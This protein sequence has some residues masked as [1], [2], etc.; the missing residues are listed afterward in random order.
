VSEDKPFDRR[1][2]DEILSHYEGQPGALIPVLQQTQEAYGYL[3]RPAIAVIAK[4][5]KMPAARVYGVATFYAQFHLKPRGK[6]IIRVCLGTACHVRGGEKIAAQLG[7]T[8]GIV[9][10]ETTADGL[11]TLE[12]VA[13]LGACGLAP[14]MVVNAATYGRLTPKAALDVIERYRSEPAEA[15][16]QG[17]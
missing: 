11:F 2:V 8:L 7:E 17:N 12:K 3:S 14:A 6:N 13:C 4:R 16:N 10:G 5:L 1:A 15:A 9:A